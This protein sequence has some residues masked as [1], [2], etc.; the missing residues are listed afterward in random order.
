MSNNFRPTV[1][2]AIGVFLA[3][4]AAPMALA[5]VP[6][7]DPLANVPE[8]AQHAPVTGT[9]SATAASADAQ[10]AAANRTADQALATAE[11]ALRAAQR[12]HA[13]QPMHHA[14]LQQG[15]HPA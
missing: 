8:Y 3:S 11:A 15:D 13:P 9:G 14:M 5:D 4:I 1:A 2:A 12:A 6:G 10:I 7:Y